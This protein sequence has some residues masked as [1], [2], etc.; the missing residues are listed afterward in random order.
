[1]ISVVF[2][3]LVGYTAR[4]EITDAEDVRELLDR[5]FAR[6]S[7]EV[8]RFGGFVEKFIGDAVMAVFGAPV[9][10]GDDAERAVRAALAIPIAI[11]KLNDEIPGAGLQVRVGVNT[12]EAVVELAPPSGGTAIVVGDMVNTASR[13]Q[14]AAPAGRVLVGDE[15]YRVTHRTIRYEAV[16][17]IVA[18]NKRDPVPAWLAIEP[19]P[20]VSFQP[21]ATPFLGRNS[22]LGLLDDVWKRVVTGRRAHLVTILGEPGIGKSRL[23]AELTHQLQASGGRSWQVR[24]LPYAQSSGYEAFG[25]LVK[26]VA[27][28]FELDVETVA[29]EKLRR[30]LDGLGLSD[31]EVT[32]RLSVFVGTGEAPAEDRREVFDAARRFVE[33]LAHEG[34][35]LLVFDDIHWAHPSML[36]LIDALAARIKDAPILLLCLARPELLD[37]R[38]MW[39]GGQASSFTIRL[40]PLA[41][42]DAHE[43][44]AH[45]TSSFADEVATQIEATAG[46]N[47]LFIEE[48]AAWVG[49]GGDREALPNTV[50]AMIAARL[51]ALPRDE[52]SVLNDAAVVGKV[53]WRGVLQGLGTGGVALDDALDSLESRDVIRTE[54]SSRVEGDREYAFRHIL[55]RD[56]AYA[57]LTKGGRRDRHEAVATFFESTLPDSDTLAAILA[58]HWQEAGH[59]ERA[60]GYLLSAAERAEL[61]WANAEAV[62]L[63]EEALS[64]IPKEEAERRRA[65]GLRRGVA[66]FRYEHSTLDEETLRRASRAEPAG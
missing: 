36:D 29:T 24:E 3:D 37:I 43:L 15:T 16:E 33:A 14:S 21:D 44:A 49:E 62:A 4:S 55:I 42:D 10:R 31:P 1:V 46:G 58:Y 38:P 64:L 52:R 39:G 35:T 20:E 34:P 19:L 26:N 17:P 45:L 56:V 2:A 32:E 60:V 66:W 18:K 6:V 23:A 27:G 51:D 7:A 40:D 12:G 57:T 28:I 5:Y 41:E 65:I 13:L 54:A 9:A 8:E 22:E 11:G 53:F 50:K 25:Q 59:P 63:Y 30:T 61:G 47:P 48:L